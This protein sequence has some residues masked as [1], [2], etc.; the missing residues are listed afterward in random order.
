VRW[1]ANE[2]TAAT[3]TPEPLLSKSKR[4]QNKVHW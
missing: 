4:M 3:G 2:T 1:D